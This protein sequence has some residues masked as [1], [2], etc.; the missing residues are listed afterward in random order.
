MFQRLK[1]FRDFYPEDCQRRHWLFGQW[2]RRADCFQ[3]REFDAPVLESLDLY[4]AKS[5]DEIVGQLFHFETQGAD[6]V[7]LRPEMTPSLAR[8]VAAKANALGRPIKWFNIGEHY[9]Y[10]QPQKG[11]LRAFYQLNA[12]LLG[13]PSPAADAEVISLLA[14][15][16]DAVGLREDEYAIRL[17][18]RALWSVFLKDLGIP[19]EAIQGV[20]TVIDR[21]EKEPRE[22]QIAKLAAQ[23]PDSIRPEALLERIDELAG[24]QSMEALTE[25]FSGSSEGEAR[26]EAWSTL[27]DAF[28]TLGLRDRMRLDLSIVRGLAYYTGFVFE[29]FQTVGSA[30]A[31][32]GGGRYDHL[33][34]KLGGPS[35]PAVGFGMGDVVLSNLLDELG[36]WPTE[37]VGPDIVF[38][39]VDDDG[40]KEALGMAAR[41]RSAGWRADYPLKRVG[42]S[43]LMKQASQRKAR[44]V[45]VLGPDE[46]ASGIVTLKN[47][48]SGVES[49]VRLAEI[50]AALRAN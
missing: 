17:S 4:R 50:E 33:V 40:Y 16:L 22:V 48:A 47:L 9:R 11:R 12:D 14:A 36:R 10:E 15:C 41:L 31:I 35:M 2:R 39:P 5:G 34:E 13:E 45:A 20:L 46:R 43:K 18:D 27:W 7:A 21:R 37:Q 29:A 30:R 44:F 49:A 28:E 38:V 32:A 23:L 24:I 1:G 19:D 25:R 3:F 26:L 6:A 8:M 42:V